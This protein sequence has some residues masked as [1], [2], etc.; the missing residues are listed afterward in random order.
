VAWRMGGMAV[1]RSSERM[2]INGLKHMWLAR[3]EAWSL[4]ALLSVPHWE[5]QSKRAL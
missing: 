2:W 4:E 3:R 1:Q 5:Y